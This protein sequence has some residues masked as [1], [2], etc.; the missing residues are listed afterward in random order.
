MGGGVD[1]AAAGEGPSLRGLTT[2]SMRCSSAELLLDHF[3]VEGELL[4]TVL[5]LRHRI[6]W[7]VVWVDGSDAYLP[8]YL[9]GYCW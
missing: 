3:L 9:L 5:L 2:E 1:A 8:C 7:M 4:V 6:R